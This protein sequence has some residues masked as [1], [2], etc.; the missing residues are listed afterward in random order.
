M[1]R[2]LLASILLLACACLLFLRL[3]S[4]AQ[5]SL[6]TI[7][8]LIRDSSGA[9][10]PNVKV[11]L[12]NQDTNQTR[13]TTSTETGLYVFP[14]VPAGNYLITV[15]HSGFK[16]F[17]GKLVLR[18]GQEAVVDVNLV[19]ATESVTVEVKDE[20]PVIETSSGTIA[21]NLESE[22]I[23]TLPLNGREITTLF[24]LTAGVTRTNGTQVNG[25]QAGSVMFL[26][27]GISMEDRY[28]GD[29][30][31]V[32]PALEGIQEFRIETLNSSAQYSKP[33]TISYLTKSGTNLIHGSGFITYRS[34]AYYARD[35]FSQNDQPPLQRREFGASVG[36][37]VYIPKVYDGKNK[38]FFF[39]TYE[40]L[41][42]PQFNTYHLG[43][44]PEDVRNGD[45]SNYI[46]LGQ[47][48]VFKIYDPLTTRL[49]PAT[50]TY[51]RDQFPNNVI[52]QDRIS[53][54]AKKA[55]PY[56]PLPNIAG[57][58]TDDNLETHLSASTHRNKYTTKID[59]QFSKDTISG[60]F[61]F[62][63]EN[64]DN[65]KGY[66]VSELI[67]FNKV[68]AKTWQV[69]L[70]D[71]HIF[72]PTIVNELR[73]GGTRPNSRRGP[74]IKNPPIT[75]VLG[76][77]NATGDSGW[78]C[79]YPYTVD[80]NVEYG[81]FF[82][83][84]DNPQ[85]APQTFWTFADN[86]SW[87][88][89]N[90]SI[91][92]GGQFRA[93]D[94]NS[95][96]IGQPRGCYEFPADWTELAADPSG[97]AVPGTG[98]GMAS[99]LL[100]YSLAGELRT[101]K[102]FFYHRQK[103]FAAYVQDDWKVSPRLTLNLGLRYEFYTRYKD[104]NDQI[105]SYD[106]VTQSMVTTT[107]IEQ[108]YLVNAAAIQ[109][110][111]NAGVTFKS[112]SEVGF[113][114]DL[115]DPQHHDFA[116]RVGFAYALDSAGKTILRGGYGISYWTIPMIGLQSRSRTNPPFD[117][118]RLMKEY[119][120]SYDYS[121][122][123]QTEFTQG[124]PP[125][126]LGGGTLAFDDTNLVIG[127]PVSMAPFS[128]HMKD[129]MAQSW[130][131]TLE[132]QLFSKTGLRLS[133]VGTHGSNLQMIEPIN[134]AAP[135]STMPGVS[136]QNRRVNP[137]YSDIGTLETYGYSNSH[138]LQAE[139]RRNVARGLTLQAFYAWNRSLA[140]TEFATGG[141]STQILGDRQSGIASQDDRI[142]LE[143]ATSSAYPANQ[144]TFNF[145][146]DLPFGPNQRWGTSTNPIV[147][148]IIGGW[149][150]AALG[151]IRSGFY[152]TY[153]NRA[154]PGVVQVSDPNLSADQRTINKWF[155]TSAFVRYAGVDTILDGRPGRNTIIG[156]G[157]RNMDFSVF[158]NTRI[159]ERLNLRL[160]VDMF[161]VFN[162]PSWGNPN[163]V[164]GRITSM[165]SS[166]RLFQFGARLDF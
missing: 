154:Q 52:P 94:L 61:T 98:S 114:S 47:T 101:N 142:G 54:L 35:P 63:D 120:P 40:G 123:G 71:T 102:G 4:V 147:S 77:Q 88:K 9:V 38:T 161:N 26:G 67:Y 95:N 29:M 85:T 133:Y 135:A 28:T 149:Q 7:N 25:V 136:T 45:F 121:G 12:Q 148:R 14:S 138:Q 159:Y 66:G 79:L 27:D 92:I 81:S 80:E 10:V 50:G 74:T 156:P 96:E 24:T 108:A 57:A 82:Y 6:G 53:N 152:L 36:G 151:S 72:S 122:V 153:A 59:Q 43:S 18:V 137:V 124:I 131:F 125:Y 2:K 109:A 105:A 46:P 21:S 13:N 107:P 140:S 84:D 145:L 139:V 118:R 17:E 19:V 49:D 69:A 115:L 37:P 110:Y 64:R 129:S 126:V 141:G 106:P 144:F 58:P 23:R 39:F 15:E 78:P 8:G 103:D 73:I 68:T 56:F 55:L 116:P 70:A 32:N 150:A 97:V 112:A 44:P 155:D 119:P 76:L 20:T 75:D 22:R 99:F 30:S 157:Y 100:G 1:N 41:R 111:E 104:K 65:P 89:K 42:Q 83:D 162:H 166:P 11:T 146:Y 160:T 3:D 34:N 93:H 33:A 134:T 113:P 130:N 86:L 158:K 16:K 87:T 117:Y 62:T 127:V 128:P 51:I 60:S 165:A 164:N 163:L 31:R 5:T 132:R 91:R 143:Y 90:H 48:S